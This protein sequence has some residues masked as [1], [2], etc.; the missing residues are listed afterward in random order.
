MKRLMKIVA[1]LAVVMALAVAVSGC[2][3]DVSE[4]V[5]SNSKGDN[6]QSSAET[7]KVESQSEEVV[8]PVTFTD[9]VI[10]KRVRQRI[11][12]EEGAIT[13]TQLKRVN[14]IDFTDEA[15]KSYEDFALLTSLESVAF[16]NVPIDDLSAVLEKCPQIT[17]LY[18]QGGSGVTDISPITKC[19]DL[20]ELQITKQDGIKDLSPISS[21]TKLEQLDLSETPVEDYSFLNDLTKLVKLSIMKGGTIDPASLNNLS[22][23][24]WLEIGE[25]GLADLSFTKNTLKLSELGIRNCGLTDISMMPASSME[26]LS[27][28]YIVSNKVSDIT[29]LGQLPNV[30]EINLANNN[31]TDISPLKDVTDTLRDKIKLKGNPGLKDLAG[32]DKYISMM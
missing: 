3:E 27:K 18:I 9:P 11:G 8:V 2:G 22:E 21:L 16:F 5:A 29:V 30:I 6:A 19:P 17:S 10:E 28:V 15:P 4:N 1:I 20:T 32:L 12:K 23:L 26:Y 7:K 31:I 13:D 25:T 14:A 24:V